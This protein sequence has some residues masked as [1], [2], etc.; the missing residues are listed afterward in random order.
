VLDVRAFESVNLQWK[1]SGDYI[2]PP[3]GG[4]CSP[5]GMQTVD[6][7]PQSNRTLSYYGNAAK[8]KSGCVGPAC[9]YKG[10]PGHPHSECLDDGEY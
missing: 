2:S 6:F 8:Q 10:V 9:S 1:M 7:A 5:V 4:A 3:G